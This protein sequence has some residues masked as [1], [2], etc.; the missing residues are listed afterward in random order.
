MLEGGSH[1]SLGVKN[2]VSFS[3]LLVVSC[4]CAKSLQSCPT[5]CDPMDCSP[6]CPWDSPGKNTGVGSHALLQGIFQTQGL[7]P[8]RMPPALAG[9]YLPLLPPVKP[10]W[11]SQSQTNA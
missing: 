8:H 5:L 1:N 2:L 6:L 4:V 11:V 7:N 10:L 9:D 3:W